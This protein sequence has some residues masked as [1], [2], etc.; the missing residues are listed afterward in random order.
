MAQTSN[1]SGPKSTPPND[2]VAAP[3]NVGSSWQGKA[4][5]L[6]VGSTTCDKDSSSNCITMDVNG[7]GL[8]AGDVAMF[9]NLNLLGNLVY[10]PGGVKPTANQVLMAN[11]T[12]GTV[13]WGDLSVSS[14]GGTCNETPTNLTG[15]TVYQNTTGT[16][17]VVVAD[18]PNSGTTNVVV[19]GY[20]GQSP[21]ALSEVAADAGGFIAGGVS[22]I[23]PPNYYYEVS[24]ATGFK[25]VSAWQIC[26]GG[27][28]VSA[29]P[30]GTVGGGCY[31]FRVNGTNNNS[32]TEYAWGNATTD[33]TT[34]KCTCPSS[35]TFRNTADVTID[36][37]ENGICVAN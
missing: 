23:V 14:S 20:I 36:G 27:N 31:N 7:S 21:T 13:K 1:W 6:T 35:Y 25:N 12:D 19:R 3:I 8:F 4:G 33:S 34:K 10:T 28:S 24:S 15:G 29:T 5:S 37:G 32:Y 18:A 16:K 22:F 9:G 2:N 30:S 26:E 17:L 11:G